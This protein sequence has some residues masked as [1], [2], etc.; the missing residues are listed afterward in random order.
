MVAS[1]VAAT[2]MSCG[3]ESTVAVHSPPQS[4]PTASGTPATPSATGLRPQDAVVVDAGRF[5]ATVVCS[6]GGDLVWP[7]S[8]SSDP[9]QY[10]SDEILASTPD[11]REPRVVATAQHG[12][13]V[14]TGGTANGWAV[15]GELLQMGSDAH[16]K[17]WYL[18]TVNIRTG[19]VIPLAE[20]T[21]QPMASEPPNATLSGDLVVW[22]ELTSAG[23][24]VLRTFVISSGARS[25][26][27]WLGVR[28]TWPVSDGQ[29]IAFLDN[30]TD[31]HASTQ[32]NATRGG[33]LMVY[34]L[35]TQRLTK[36]DSAPDARQE[37]MA[38]SLIAW[39]GQGAGGNFSVWLSSLD[40][41]PAKQ[42][43][44]V[45]YRIRLSSTKLMWTGPEGTFQYR[46]DSQTTTKLAVAPLQ[47][48]KSWTPSFALCGNAVYYSP[49][50]QGA[51]SHP[52][53]VHLGD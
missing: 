15:V 44:G 10:K 47:D 1:L 37:V 6:P 35:K 21:T 12:G 48:I 26:L 3:A 52:I 25:T 18:S 24:K 36:P 42:I 23:D 30:A 16:W 9:A 49:I 8:S 20:S 45:G 27:S 7:S 14:F 43:S 11:R 34:D 51:A 41:S 19:Q 50:Y 38:G 2:T 46:L 40:G 4:T 13:Q 53:Y 29:L 39:E 17:F 31:P 22:D 5:Q 32:I 28:P 33:H